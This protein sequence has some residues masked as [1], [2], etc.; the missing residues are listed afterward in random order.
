MA[1][2][3][4]YDERFLDHDTGGGHP[5][6]R[7]RLPALVEA[8]TERGLV[9]RM[10]AMDFGTLPTERLHHVHDPLYVEQV[11]D[12]F[13]EGVRQLDPDTLISEA[14]YDVA[15]LASGA[16][17]AAADAVMG[18]SG[19]GEAG[20]SGDGGGLK[21]A[22]CAMRP[23]GHHAEHDRAMGFCLFNHIAVA[24]D[25]LVRAHGL[26]RVAIVDFDVHHGN[27]TQHT[28]EERADVLFVSIH[29]DPRTIFPGTGFAEETGRGAGEGFTLNVP[30]P[31]GS[32]D[33]DYREAFEGKV[34][35][36]V[37][38]YEPQVLLISAGF[39]AA[40][41]D[42]LGQIE[43]TDAAFAWMTQQLAALADRFAGGRI[44]SLLEGGY[45]LQ[46][47]GRD[48]ATHVEALLA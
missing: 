7:E 16:A 43:L 27:G 25:H 19:D 35:P 6:R 31:P 12:A 9:Q 28:F 22:F 29:Q 15:R 21:R 20:D 46:A 26:E 18:R 38:A 23:P 33:R 4:A 36:K 30:M 32:G 5:E 41:E 47:L 11:R 2:G 42:P 37:E 13:A 1:V 17:V 44:I 34:L 24:A 3:F 14:S 39:D 8:L 40:R 10:R 45:D 48:A